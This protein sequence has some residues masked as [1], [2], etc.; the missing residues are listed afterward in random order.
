MENIH[1][2]LII[3]IETSTKACSVA[4]SKGNRLIAEKYIF[5]ERSHSK[6][7]LPFID[8]IFKDNSYTVKKLDAV[9]VS[10]GPGSYTG[11]RIGLSVAKGLCYGLGI[12]LIS[13]NSLDIMT[14]Q[15]SNM[16][17]DEF[18]LCAA[19]DARRNE[20]YCSVAKTLV[21]SP[22]LDKKLSHDKE[23]GTQII[24]P[25]TSKIITS[26]SF[27]N[28]LNNNKMLFFGDGAK[29]CIEILNNPNAILIENITPRAQYMTTL[30]N[31]KYSTNFFE[32]IST[33]EPL[34]LKSPIDIPKGNHFKQT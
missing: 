24:E 29:K 7:V 14:H 33:F 16:N 8:Q 9:A 17:R 32:S 25:T 26:D 20:V 10:S 27:A 11:L 13:I 34:Y 28:I 5:I 23:A 22:S 12:P 31:D 4:I 30:A 6:H 3:C 21:N 1:K 19:I 15:V 18:F 2:P